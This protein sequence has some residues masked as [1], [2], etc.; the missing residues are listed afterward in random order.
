[1]VLV[2]SASGPRVSGC[3]RAPRYF[4]PYPVGIHTTK[5]GTGLLPQ[6][7][8]DGRGRGERRRWQVGDETAQEEQ[9]QE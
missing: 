8:D 9:E 7:G 6:C 4:G 1:M 3:T 2:S 5:T